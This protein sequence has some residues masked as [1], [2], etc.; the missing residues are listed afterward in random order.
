MVCQAIKKEILGGKLEILIYI[1]DIYS[2]D[3]IMNFAMQ[4]QKTM[5]YLPEHVKDRIKKVAEAEGT[6]QAKVI[7]VALE[8]GLGTAKFQKDASARS[9]L[10]LAEIGRKYQTGSKPKTN[11]VEEI[12]KMWQAW[13]NGNEQ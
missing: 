1:L 5:M 11:A 7:R 12:D 8:V 4:M 9:L 13:G 6:S 3:G 10:K 2:I